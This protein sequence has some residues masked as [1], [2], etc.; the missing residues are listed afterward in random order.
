MLS[1]KCSWMIRAKLGEKVQDER[2][3]P[4]P[5]WAVPIAAGAFG[6]FVLLLLFGIGQTV[7]QASVALTS[8]CCCAAG[9]LPYGFLPAWIATRRD[10]RLTPGQGFAV[11]FIGV[12]LGT[13]VWAVLNT[14]SFQ[15]VDPA[16][17]R[18]WFET[19]QEGMPVEQRRSK[20]EI[21]QMFE[22]T[23]ALIPYVPAIYATVTTLLAGF[24]GM[25]TVRIVRGRARPPEV[26]AP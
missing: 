12:G 25:L 23:R 24:V 13:V 10:P 5:S 1:W 8:A 15:Q 20:E 3:E 21:D 7:P 19:A 14:P 11:A 6:T 26:D 17:L 22:T 16:L 9:F 4:T 18:E 2:L